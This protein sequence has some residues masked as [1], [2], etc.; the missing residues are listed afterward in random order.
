[1]FLEQN[2]FMVILKNFKQKIFLVKS[3]D[4]ECVVNAS[5][6]SE[7]CSKALEQSMACFSEA[8]LE[9]INL[10]FLMSCQEFEEDLEKIS[11]I[12]TSTILAN[13]G[14]YELAKELENE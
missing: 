9:K 11:Y 8:G 14:Q 4:W 3:G 7:A 1:M 10:G 6:I 5:D 12:H 2:K 13:N